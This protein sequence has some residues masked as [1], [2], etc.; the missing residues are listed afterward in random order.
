MHISLW[1]LGFSGYRFVAAA[2]DVSFLLKAR[3]EFTQKLFDQWLSLAEAHR[4]VTSLL[5]DAMAG[6]P[7]NVTG[8]ASGSGPATT[9]S[10]PSMFPGSA[11]SLSPRS[12]GSPRSVKTEGSF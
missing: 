10:L 5:Q 8:S 7:L 4:Q 11:P 2:E 12:C 9:T 3:P 6:A 1:R